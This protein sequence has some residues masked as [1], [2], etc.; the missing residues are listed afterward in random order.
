MLQKKSPRD[1]RGFFEASAYQRVTDFV[2]GYLES[3]FCH[4]RCFF[5][6]ICFFSTRTQDLYFQVNTTPDALSI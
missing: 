2:Q 1:Q 5:T 4:F 3:L 6:R